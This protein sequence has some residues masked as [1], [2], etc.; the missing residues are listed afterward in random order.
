M[1]FFLVLP[2]INIYCAYTGLFINLPTC[3]LSEKLDSM[4]IKLR[5]HLM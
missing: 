1:T 2:D 4:H 5:F 3:L